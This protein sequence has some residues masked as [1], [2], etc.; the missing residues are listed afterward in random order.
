[1]DRAGAARQNPAGPTRTYHAASQPL[2]R[3]VRRYISV[4]IAVIALA[5]LS[6]GCINLSPVAHDAEKAA[7]GAKDSTYELRQTY[8]GASGNANNAR[9]DEMSEIVQDECSDG[10]DSGICSAAP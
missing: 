4:A 7:T 10:D 2:L 1:M 5:L 9:V 3:T 8:R 6:G